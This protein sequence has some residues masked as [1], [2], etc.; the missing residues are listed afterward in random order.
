MI[1]IICTKKLSTGGAE[2][3]H[4]LCFELNSIGVD[5]NMGYYERKKNQFVE[6]E[7]NTNYTKYC[8]Y[9]KT[10]K[11]QDVSGNTIVFPETMAYLA[12]NVKNAKV[13]I[14]WL[15]I[16][17]Y[18]INFNLEY[19]KSNGV[20][21]T[22]NELK[23]MFRRPSF[24]MLAGYL[25]ISQ[26]VYAKEFL[27]VKGI[28]SSIVSDYLNTEFVGENC[29]LKK[30]ENIICYNPKKGLQVTKKIMNY[31]EKNNS[32]FLFVPII[33]MNAAGVKKLMQ[34]SKI[35]IDFG[36][37]P[38]KDRM[39]RE[40]R[41]QDCVIITGK[42]GSANNP[43]DISINAIYKIN[44]KD[45]DFLVSLDSLIHKIVDSFDSHLE[46]QNDYKLKILDEKKQF[47]NQVIDFV[48]T[49]EIDNE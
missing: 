23:K 28:N 47:T 7:I 1:Q 19:A 43:I 2:L 35:Y 15:S 10:F 4:Q 29:D 22:L 39:P 31:Y 17:N 25:H 32:N 40:A 8:K 5:S 34:K 11:L 12:K 45:N 6:T 42:K 41:I 49:L 46:N 27:Y 18:L 26:S 37:H 14:W 3:L 38:G 9:P 24:S 20:K 16:D 36:G 33:G 30:K 21:A 44:E 48:K 13:V